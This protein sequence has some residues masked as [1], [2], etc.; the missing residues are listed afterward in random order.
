MIFEIQKAYYLEARNP[1]DID[2]LQILA[3]QLGLDAE[4]FRKDIASSDTEAELQRQIDSLGHQVWP[5]FRRWPW[6]RMGS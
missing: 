5:G 6:K 4:T 1:S 2:T 3:E